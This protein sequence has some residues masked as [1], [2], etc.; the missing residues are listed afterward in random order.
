MNR[1][2]PEHSMSPFMGEELGRF[3]ERP[4]M[5]SVGVGIDGRRDGRQQGGD[6]DAEQGMGAA[7]LGE[8]MGKGR[9]PGAARCA[10]VEEHG[11]WPWRELGRGGAVEDDPW[12]WGPPVGEG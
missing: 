3:C 8:T 6:G 4:A 5:R 12:R 1:E 10:G 2:R 9:K 7:W 11:A